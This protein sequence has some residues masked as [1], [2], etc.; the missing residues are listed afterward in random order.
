MKKVISLVLVLSI[1]CTMTTSAL[2]AEP[3]IG[4]TKTDSVYLSNEM[5]GWSAAGSGSGA[6]ILTKA[7]KKQ[8]LSK[9]SLA[10]IPFLDWVLIVSGLLG[11]WSYSTGYSGLKYTITYKYDEWEVFDG[12]WTTYTGWNVTKHKFSR[13]K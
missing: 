12:E 1:F 8:I 3:E 13:Y 2:A 5:L 6:A 11:A 4:D 9:T 10:V 7:A